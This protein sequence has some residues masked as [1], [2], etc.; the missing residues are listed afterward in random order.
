M[1]PV[2]Q[3]NKHYQV[4]LASLLTNKRGTLANNVSAFNM[5]LAAKRWIK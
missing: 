3:P 5:D 2:A 1:K 4:M